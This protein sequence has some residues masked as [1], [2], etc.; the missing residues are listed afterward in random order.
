VVLVVSLIPSRTDYRTSTW[1][2]F[3]CSPICLKLAVLST[4]IMGCMCGYWGVCHGVSVGQ[5]E[6]VDS[7]YHMCL[8]I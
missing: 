6:R 1:H 3:V 4:F 7:F 2:C 8:G 5:V